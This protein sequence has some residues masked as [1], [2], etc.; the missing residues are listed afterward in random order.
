MEVAERELYRVW[1]GMSEWDTSG[2]LLS[3]P[4]SEM[5]SKIAEL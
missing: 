2:C 5:H 4:I 1:S 3:V